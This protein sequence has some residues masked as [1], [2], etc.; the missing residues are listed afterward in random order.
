MLSEYGCGRLSVYAPTSGCSTD[1]QIWYVR[2]I[3]PI[4]AKLSRNSPFNRG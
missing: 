2:V 1:A 3:A 4:C